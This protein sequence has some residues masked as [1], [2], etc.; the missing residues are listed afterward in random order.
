M[1]AAQEA[2]TN[3]RYISSEVRFYTIDDVA[4]LTG[5]SERVIRKLFN[6]PSFPT[7]DY[8][9]MKIVEAHALIDFFSSRRSRGNE[10][11]SEKGEVKNELKSRIR[12]R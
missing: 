12:K 4:K 8:G 7:S 9:K 6:D 3:E 2:I 10:K 5:W 11:K 1:I